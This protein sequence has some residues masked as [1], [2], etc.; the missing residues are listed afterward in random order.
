MLFQ[1]LAITAIAVAMTMV[2]EVNSMVAQKKRDVC[3]GNT[4]TDRATWC[5]YDLD[6]NYYTEWPDTGV[7]REYWFT[8]EQITAAPDGIDR[9]AYA[10]NGSIP[11]PTIYADWGDWVTVHVTNTLSEAQNG[12]SIHWHG[13]RQYNT[14]QMDGVSSITQCPTA[15]GETITYTWQATQY[16]TSWYH[17]HIG[18]QA[19]EGVAGGIMINGPAST[20]YDEDKGVLLLGDWDHQTMDELYASDLTNG[21]PELDNSLINGT[22]IYTDANN[23]TTGYYFNTSFTAGTSY[24]FRLINGAINTHFMFSIDNHTLTVIATDLVPIAPYETDVLSIAMGERY[25]VI[26][27]ANQEDVAE[28]FWMRAIPQSACSDTE[29]EGLGIIYYGD[30]PSTP[31]TTG[32]DY[33]AGCDDEDM[34]NLVPYLSLDVGDDTW[35]ISETVTINDPVSGIFIWYFDDVSMH[36]E[37]SNPTLLQVYNDDTAFSNTSSVNLLSSED[38][39]AYVVV[40]T[41]NNVQHPLHLHGHDFFVLAQG[42]GDYSAADISLTNPPRRDTAVLPAAGYVVLAFKTDNPGAW[43]MHCHI[44]WHTDMGLAIQF[45]EDYDSTRS[46]IDYDTLIDNCK[47]WDNYTAITDYEQYEWDDGI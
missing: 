44:G 5:D 13:I 35:N 40:T 18:L 15:P 22:N 8:V 31:T 42:T 19:W 12:T 33:T 39:W 36:L 9:V 46:L 1:P 37:W 14:N 27:T 25:D 30:D 7:T 28:N 3:S 11:G 29:N 45:I 20:N 34:S 4:A 26:V 43:L 6:T 16:G 2:V 47:A 17:A 10:I 24:R 32:Y 23:I 41:T 38:E 21:P